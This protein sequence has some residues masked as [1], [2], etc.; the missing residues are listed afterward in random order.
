MSS[1][2]IKHYFWLTALVLFFPIVVEAQT[3]PTAPTNLHVTSAT[4][5]GISLAWQDNS[6]YDDK[7]NIY[8]KLTTDTYWPSM[9]LIQI[10]GSNVTS[11]TDTAVTAGSYYDYYVEA[12]LSGTGCSAPSNYLISIQAG[13]ASSSCTGLT[14][15]TNKTSYTVGETVNYTWNCTP[16]GTASAV[17]IYLVYPDYH[18]LLLNTTSGAGT[19]SNGLSTTG[20]SSGSYTLRA[21][22][23][24]SCSTVMASAPFSLTSSGGGSNY[25]PPAS[26]YASQSG[27][28]IYVSWP[29]PSP[30]PPMYKIERSANGTTFA[31]LANGITSL[32][33]TDSSSLTTSYAYSYKVYSCSNSSTCSSAGTASN[34]ITYSSSGGGG[35]GGTIPPPPSSLSATV[36]NTSVNLVWPS[37]SSATHYNLYRSTYPTAG[38]WTSVCASSATVGSCTDSSVPSGQYQYRLEACASGYGCSGVIN[39][40]WI[41]SSAV[42]VGSSSNSDVGIAPPAPGMPLGP[43]TALLGQTV[44]VTSTLYSS[45]GDLLKAIFDWGDGTSFGYSSAITTS[46]TGTVSSSVSHSYNTAGTYYVRAKA[47]NAA[48]VESGW[49]GSLAI[50]VVSG[51]S[52]AIPAAPT[53]L[54]LESVSNAGIYL[55]WTDNSNNEDKF[56][57]ER[58]LT[59]STDWPGAVTVQL[60]DANITSY[61][62]TTITSGTTYDYRVQACLSGTGCS[63][64]TT[65]SGVTAGTMPSTQVAQPVTVQMLNGAI[66]MSGLVAFV[67]DGVSVNASFNYTSSAQVYLFPGTYDIQPGFPGVNSSEVRLS[68]TLVDNR[69]FTMGTTGTVVK[70]SLPTRLSA[71]VVVRNS[72]GQPLANARVEVGVTGTT[73]YASADTDGSGVA[74]LQ[75]PAG[76]YQGLVT[77]SGYLAQTINLVVATAAVELNV[78]LE[79]LSITV[80]GKVLV[81]TT[82]K[83][84]AVVRAVH[85]ADGAIVI[86]ST[87]DSGQYTIALKTGVWHLSAAADGY[88]E[89][90]GGTVTLNTGSQT[91]DITLGAPVQLISSS[92]NIVPTVSVT[93]TA[94]DLGVTVGLPANALGGGSAAS[95]TIRESSQAVVTAAARPLPGSV[96]EVSANSGGLAVTNLGSAAS[97]E[98]NYTEA[99]LTAAGVSGTETNNLKLAFWDTERN[100]WEVLESVVDTANRKVRGTTTHLTLFAIVLPFLAQPASAEVTTPETTG[101]TVTP[102]A[103]P[104]DERAAQFA[105]IVAE[106]TKV[107]VSGPESLAMSVNVSR[108]PELEQKYE[109][110]IVAR[111]VGSDKTTSGVKSAMV[112]FVTY[113]TTSTIHLGAG[114]RGGVVSSFRAAYGHL[115]QSEY[116]WQEVLKIANGRWPG[117]LLQEREQAMKSTFKKI[118]LRE[119]VVT[120]ANDSAALAIMAYGLR[121]AKRNLSSEA[122][123]VETFRVI[124]GQTPATATDWDAVRAAAYSGAKQ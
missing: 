17:A 101:T 103:T 83:T 27:R 14:L 89:V 30:T 56:N 11:Y 7:V 86:V 18:T 26:V 5:S 58:K 76:T 90:D 108:N 19:N 24:T 82:P 34:S 114:E 61:N 100:D 69:K 9:Y 66:V 38:T 37:V 22:F 91:R 109:A 33:Y 123:A 64:Y 13:T 80:N 42:T 113:G 50:T 47:K 2:N 51:G 71:N 120:Q 48:G 53:N 94:A 35:T 57:I 99:D 63:T 31:V 52:G 55:K 23:D 84:N 104:T 115:P 65:L 121:S 116:E 21:C 112:N 10:M 122:A 54:R 32:T 20:F 1:R 59:S 124:Y 118:Y 96:R 81:G 40:Q 98:F 12:C 46:A 45:T 3:V 93:V 105:A 41:Y 102:P 79:S 72:A 85:A 62:D 92:A 78:T 36:S 107:Y 70:V 28:A 73:A 43:A 117:T 44:T 74:W 110:D 15:T 119:A 16:G 29:V 106:G 97:I 67:R 6:D 49:S 77:K 39:S 25:Y 68:G 88:T 75:L 111:V 4:S 8:R 60:P 87:N 95:V